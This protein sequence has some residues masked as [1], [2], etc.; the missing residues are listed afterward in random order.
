MPSVIYI[1]K[2]KKFE[3][4][5]TTEII[6]YMLFIRQNMCLLFYVPGIAL[7][8]IIRVT[9]LLI[10]SY[11]GRLPAY[12]LQYYYMIF[13]DKMILLFDKI[14]TVNLWKYV[15][16]CFILYIYTQKYKYLNIK[17]KSYFTT[18]IINKNFH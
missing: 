9:N 3:K 1:I 11:K 8:L 15:L 2:R 16:Y 17:K 13:V 5:F 12:A 18:P 7:E 10:I 4:N 6:N 14:L